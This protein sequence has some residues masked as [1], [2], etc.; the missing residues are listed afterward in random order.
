VYFESGKTE[1]KQSGVYVPHGSFGFG[2]AAVLAPKPMDAALDSK[3]DESR[4]P[5]HGFWLMRGA[6]PATT[7]GAR[8]FCR[9]PDSGT[10]HH[11]AKSDEEVNLALAVFRAAD[12]TGFQITR[13]WREKHTHL[14]HEWCE[15]L[16]LIAMNK[17]YAD[18]QQML[19]KNV[20]KWFSV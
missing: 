7:T 17:L 5:K 8:L 3:N 6:Q 12:L 16:R 4:T 20:E 11:P 10:L 14:L 19:R 2:M 15:I 13:I 9:K 1:S 18:S